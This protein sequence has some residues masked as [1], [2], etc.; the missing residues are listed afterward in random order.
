MIGYGPLI[1]EFADVMTN[2]VVLALT[3]ACDFYK[4]SWTESQ[5]FLLLNH[6]RRFK[7]CAVFF[8]SFFP[9]FKRFSQPT[10]SVAELRLSSRSKV[11]LSR[12]HLH[13][14]RKLKSSLR[15]S[16]QVCCFGNE[17]N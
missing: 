8:F 4:A 10:C 1:I 15:A 2:G 14:C 9:R 12:G 6:I 13:C 11:S 16:V 5:H 3:G 17:S 7:I